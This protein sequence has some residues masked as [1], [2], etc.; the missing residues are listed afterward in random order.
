ME[1]C[2]GDGG[3]VSSLHAPWK[4]PH[5]QGQFSAWDAISDTQEL[6]S[7]H[8]EELSSSNVCGFGIVSVVQR[9]LV[10]RSSIEILLTVTPVRRTSFIALR[11]GV[12]MEWL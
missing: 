7:D 6:S 11:S 2:S 5:W 8:S 3:S 10:K 4:P 9:G 1:K 12:D